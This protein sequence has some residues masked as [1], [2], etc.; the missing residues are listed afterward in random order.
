MLG[1]TVGEL[2]PFKDVVSNQAMLELLQKD[3]YVRYEDLPLETKDGRHIAVEFVSNVYQA[4]DRRVIQCNIRDVTERKKIEQRLH[5]L[6]T[7]LSNLN[8]VILVTEAANIDE[9]EPRIVYANK[10][11]E[12]VTGYTS[13]EALGHSPRFLQGKKTDRHILAEI[14]QALVEKKAIRRQ[15]VNYKKDGGEYWMDIDIVPILNAVGKCTHFAAIER[16][17]TESKRNEARFRLLTD[18][19]AQGVIFWNIKGEISGGNDAFLKLVQYT[20]EDLE[21]GRINS[22]AMTPPE[23]AHLDRRALDQLAETRICTPYEKEFILKDGSRVSILLGAAMFEDNPNEGICF[24]IDLTERKNS[25][26][27]S[28]VRNAWKVSALSPGA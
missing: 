6:E 12:R 7:C 28:F 9:P 19:N 24:V 13:A 8:D 14:R 22:V 20:R 11:F 18:S 3:G 4:G 1:K 23:S 2:S 21:G 25:N 16:D 26:S 5:L 10:A 27:N 15:V 17:V